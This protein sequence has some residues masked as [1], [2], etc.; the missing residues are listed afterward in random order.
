MKF[1]EFFAKRHLFANLFTL[2]VFALGAKALFDI[3]RNLFPEV[4]MGEMIITTPYPGASPEDVELKVTNKLEEELDGISGIRN[5]L[6]T[7]VENR[8]RINIKLNPDDERDHPKI[9]QEIRDAINQVSDLPDELEELPRITEITTSIFPVVEVAVISETTPYPKL[10]SIAKV[11]KEKIADLPGVSKVE[12]VGLL[13]REVKI[14][15]LPEKLEQYQVSLGEIVSAIKARNI[16]LTG[17]SFEAYT[18]EKD[19]VT[20]AQFEDPAEVGEVIV[21]STFEGPSVK[22][23]D[24]AVIQD[25]YEKALVTTRVNGKRAISLV[26]Y[27]N[28]SSDVIDTVD[29]IRQIVEREQQ[30]IGEEIELVVANDSSH[31]IRNR[32]KIVMTNGGLGLIFIVLFLAI[33]LN[34]RTA[35]W[36]SVSIPFMMLSVLFLVNAMG[37]ALDAIMLMG[38]IIVLG[39]VVD[40]AIIISESIYRHHEM[41]EDPLPAAIKGARRVFLPVLTTILTTMMAFSTMFFMPGIMGKFCRVIPIAVSLALLVSLVEVTVALPAH[42]VPGLRKAASR[43]GKKDWFENFRKPYQF[44]LAIFLKLR[45]LSILG[46][47]AV[48]VGSLYYAANNIPIEIFPK[49]SSFQ[50][51]VVAELPLGSSLEATADKIKEVEELIASLPKKEVDAFA[52]RVGQTGAD[53]GPHEFRENFGVISVFL[54]PFGNGRRNAFKI[55]EELREKTEAL[56][57]FE[58]LDFRIDGGGPPVGKPITLRA[59][60]SDNEIRKRLADRIEAELDEI[61]GIKDITR[62]DIDGKKQVRIRVDYDKLARTN[63]QV[64]D[65]AQ[66]V[67]TAYDGEIVTSVRYGDEDVDYRVQFAP[68]SRRSP[69][70][71][72]KVLVKNSTG[73]LI[74]LGKVSNFEDKPGP[75]NF[76]HYNGKRSTTIDAEVVK[77]KAEPLKAANKVIDAIDLTQPEFIGARIVLDGEAQETKEAMKAWAVSL[78]IAVVGIY[79][80]LVLLFN[81]FLQPLLVLTAIP[82]GVS[83]VIIAVAF[84]SQTIS[85]FTMLGVIGLVGVVVNDSL[86]LVNHLNQLKD[87]HP[88]WSIRKIVIEGSADRL[89]AIVMTSI[90]TIAGLLPLA[91]GIG[92]VDPFV[93]YMALALGWGLFLSTPLTLLLLP[94][95]YYIATPSRKGL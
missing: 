80:M 53:G 94:C 56:E 42:L 67:R 40:D 60:S 78:A 1:F 19:I 69:E 81:S 51:S 47:V 24:L 33:F 2:I 52:T 11:L 72:K 10:R 86:V 54:T 64:A 83:G 38:L 15:V 5:Y 16:R 49:E 4:D 74:E 71:L 30:L 29:S 68:E 8:S 88:D 77:G 92:G 90:T 45:Y 79:F 13:D 21:R 66:T 31:Y 3:N 75:S 32:F 18:G 82:F 25:D 58:S 61:E 41:G 65:V 70:L 63:L 36:V 34:W 57:G 39:I 23:K 7:S 91:Y 84:H 9:K 55:V 50:L 73:K 89:R 76:Y 93:G 46:F 26:P 44:L 14:E 6:S 48:L 20:L 59:V 43:K 87:E 22:V 12:D 28:S 37:M 95:L 27:K 35:F 17:G 62:D 85:F